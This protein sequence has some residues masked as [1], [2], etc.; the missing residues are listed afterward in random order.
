MILLKDSQHISNSRKTGSESRTP[1]LCVSALSA[2][3]GRVPV[4]KDTPPKKVG[5][6]RRSTRIC[7]PLESFVI[8]NSPASR[9]K[10]PAL[11]SPS[12]TSTSPA[13]VETSARL[14]HS[15]RQHTSGKPLQIGISLSFGS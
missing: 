12:L 1:Q 9:T 2:V 10:K 14:L 15:H 5:A 7:C 11:V 13:L 8:T 6:I 3:S 4:S